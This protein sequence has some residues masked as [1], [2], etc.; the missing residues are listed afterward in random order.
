[1][2][3][4]AGA[5]FFKIRF[6]ENL[7]SAAVGYETFKGVSGIVRNGGPVSP[8]NAF[9]RSCLISERNFSGYVWIALKFVIHGSRPALNIGGLR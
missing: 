6:D 3:T 7:T 2:C 8:V 5:K 4:I 1:M 9:R